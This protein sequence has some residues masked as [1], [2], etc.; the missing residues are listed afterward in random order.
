[1]LFTRAW[2]CALGELRG[3]FRVVQGYMWGRQ[4]K[5]EGGRGGPG[6][7]RMC[8][9]VQVPCAGRPEGRG[10]IFDGFTCVLPNRPQTTGL[11]RSLLRCSYS[12]VYC[13]NPRLN[14]QLSS[15]TLLYV[16]T[17]DS[18][19]KSTSNAPFYHICQSAGINWRHKPLPL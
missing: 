9:C 10:G 14:V 19:W 11:C 13:S 12:D 5:R 1:M 4:R 3:V 16:F 18:F 8:V 17:G 2:K 7:A 15:T 6:E